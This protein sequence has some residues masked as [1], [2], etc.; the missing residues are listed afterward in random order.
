MMSFEAIQ[1]QVNES[2]MLNPG[3]LYIPSEIRKRLDFNIGD[4]FEVLANV[5]DRELLI[6]KKEN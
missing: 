3:Q 4:K 6:R 1:K 5:E 2:K